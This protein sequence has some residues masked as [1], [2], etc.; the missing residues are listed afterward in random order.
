[1]N[2]SQFKEALEK[3]ERAPA[4]K[5]VLL[6]VLAGHIDTEIAVKTNTKEG[7]VRKQ[8]SKIYESFGIKGE[9][10]GDRRPRRDDLVAQFRKY[11]PE[12]VTDFPAIVKNEVSIAQTA[13]VAEQEGALAKPPQESVESKAG[14]GENLTSLATSIL[15]Q[16]GFEQKFKMNRTS[17]YTGYR[18][19]NP[20]ERT[21]SYLLVLAQYKDGLGISISRNILNP[22][23]LELKFYDDVWVR[24]E[25]GYDEADCQ[26]LNHLYWVIPSKED[27]FLEIS[28]DYKDIFSGES[29]GSFY[30]DPKGID[31]DDVI[32]KDLQGFK[33]KPSEAP[34]FDWHFD[35]GD[36]L[37]RLNQSDCC[38]SMNNIDRLF[39]HT[40]KAYINSREILEEFIHYF[41]EIFMDN[42]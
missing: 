2:R 17:Q 38:I 33:L 37:V 25:Y 23:V 16:L 21:K 1:M 3:L 18:L 34:G 15:E 11:K 13:E 40:R 10:E 32:H 22:Y 5:K 39:P 27:I 35:H 29:T 41:G 42:Y 26:E 14:S 4:K 12:W 8:I 30:L 24:N 36:L 7:T 28:Q 9:Y 31:T 20:G 19:K 6:L